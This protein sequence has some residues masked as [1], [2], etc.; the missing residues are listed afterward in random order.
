MEECVKLG[1]TKSIGISNFNTEQIKRVLDAATIKPAVNQVKYSLCKYEGVSKSFRTESI[2]KYT[3][4]TINTRRE[5]TQ[6]VMAEKLTRLTHK[7]AIRLHLVTES[8][9]ICGS[10]PRR[11]VRNLLGTPLYFIIFADQAS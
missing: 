7:I 3:L 9:I 1:L 10:R 6:R 8:C 4:I 2:T 11:P 5:A